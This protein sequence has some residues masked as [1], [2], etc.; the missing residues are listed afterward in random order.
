MVERAAQSAVLAAANGS[1]IAVALACFIVGVVGNVE[2]LRDECSLQCDV[3]GAARREALVDGPR[4]GAVVHDGVVV[5]CHA[6]SVEPF[7]GV[8]VVIAQPHADEPCNAVALHAERCT[9]KHDAPPWRCLSGY[10]DILVRTGQPSLQSD[11][12]CH[13][14]DDGARSVHLCDA[15]AECAGLWAVHI[16][17]ERRDVVHRAASAANGE[18]SVALSIGECQA[19]WTERPCV[20]LVN[21]AILVLFVYAPVVGVHGAEAAIVATIGR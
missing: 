11:G 20:A 7:V 3:L 10:G 17:V 4:Y 15:V 16:V 19:P 21:V 1:G 6:Q 14:E 5:A 2:C 8:T 9:A 13:V 18:A 12:A